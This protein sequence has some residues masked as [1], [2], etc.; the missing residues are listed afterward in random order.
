LSQP[1]WGV[2][3]NIEPGSGRYRVLPDGRKMQE[4]RI[5]VTRE[6]MEKMWQGYMCAR[7]FEDF[8]ARGMAAF[9]KACPLCHFPVAELQRQQLEQD[10]VGEVEE[11]RRDGWIERE[12]EFL[13]REFFV[14]KPGIHVR[15][16]L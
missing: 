11:L 13:E 7:C 16:D 14:P 3:T 15:R 6:A 5:T 1:E 12:E 9:P 2:V 8:T 10:F 4:S